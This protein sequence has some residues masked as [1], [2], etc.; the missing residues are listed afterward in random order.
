MTIKETIIQINHLTQLLS[1][2]SWAFYS[3]YLKSEVS[4]HYQD[5]VMADSPTLE[6]K[7]LGAHH[8]LTQALSW[9]ERQIDLLREHL[10]ELEK[11]A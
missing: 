1:S 3:E 9:P 5:A 4:R 2:Q 7:N 8:A 10:R 6:G 11:A